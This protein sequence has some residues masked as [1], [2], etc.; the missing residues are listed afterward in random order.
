MKPTEI[1]GGIINL[2][3]GDITN[4]FLTPEGKNV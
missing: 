2:S 4:N 3:T 1:N